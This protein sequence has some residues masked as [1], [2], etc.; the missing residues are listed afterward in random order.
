MTIEVALQSAK[1]DMGEKHGKTLRQRDKKASYMS[2]RL[3][4]ATAEDGVN[5]FWGRH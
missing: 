4:A 1:I 3:S 2:S 5:V